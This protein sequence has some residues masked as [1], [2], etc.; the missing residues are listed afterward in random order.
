MKRLKR[1]RCQG[2]P[3]PKTFFHRQGFF[4][5]QALPGAWVSLHPNGRLCCPG[6]E[7]MLCAANIKTAFMRRPRAKGPDP[8]PGGSDC[9]T[10]EGGFGKSWGFGEV[11]QAGEV[12]SRGRRRVARKETMVGNHC[13]CQKVGAEM[14]GAVKV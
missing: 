11:V 9:T 10:P 7:F 5:S 6:Y 12:R 3:I 1:V 2:Q 4:L 14:E 13:S 8:C